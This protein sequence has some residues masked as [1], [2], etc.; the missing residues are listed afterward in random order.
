MFFRRERP[1]IVSF[2]ERVDL[3]KKAGFTTQPMPDGRVKIS[4]L[5]IGAIIGDEGKQQAG[6][7]RIGILLGSEIATLLNVGY[8]MLLETPGGKRMPAAADQLKALHEFE[9]DVKEALDLTN[10]Y[11]TSL[12]TTSRKHVYDRVYKRDIGEQPKPWLK[13]DHKIGEPDTKGSYSH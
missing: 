5:G 7:E 9:D 11:N 10:L 1:K 8:Q 2:A 12:G 6:I 13:K 4:K 3:L